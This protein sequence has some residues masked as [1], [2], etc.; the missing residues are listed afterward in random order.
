MEHTTR[1]EAFSKGRILGIIHIFRLLL[2][3]EMIQISEEF[4]E[5]VLRRQEL[6]LISKVVLAKL[7]GGV[8]ERL[9]HLGDGRILR[10]KSDVCAG[11][12]YF[13]QPGMDGRLAGD[14]CCAARR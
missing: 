11:Q 5:A 7:S 2:R 14:K 10:P 9:E 6:V 1:T 12:A 3:I 4:V 8:A 13:R